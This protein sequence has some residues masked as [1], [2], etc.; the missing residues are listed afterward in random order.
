MSPIPTISHAADDTPAVHAATAT[1]PAVPEE[2]SSSSG[3]P[4]DST[5]AAAEEPQPAAVA[6]PAA[7]AA[8]AARRREQSALTV[9]GPAPLGCQTLAWA[10]PRSHFYM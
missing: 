2:P 5:K 10:G 6:A 8:A 9:C 1:A 4:A 3:G 7:L